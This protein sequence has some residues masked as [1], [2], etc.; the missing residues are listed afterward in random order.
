L[1][2]GA[3]RIE[4]APSEPDSSPGPELD[5]STASIRRADGPRLEQGGLPA[6]AATQAGSPSRQRLSNGRQ[7]NCRAAAWAHLPLFSSRSV[8]SNEPASLRRRTMVCSATSRNARPSSLPTRSGH[9]SS[10]RRQRLG[11]LHLDLGGA[12]RAAVGAGGDVAPDR[13]SRS[14]LDQPCAN[15]FPAG[16][17][18]KRQGSE[19]AAPGCGQRRLHL[20]RGLE[21]CA[22]TPLWIVSS[23]GFAWMAKK[24]HS[25]RR[26]RTLEPWPRERLA[27]HELEA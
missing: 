12:V 8:L 25:A 13:R 9:R 27:V 10:G 17:V 23:A 24:G 22:P 1:R 4:E 26:A 19:L 20:L 21:V 18:P 6:C 16:R 14:G 7:T 2:G 3:G 15:R 11:R 5:L